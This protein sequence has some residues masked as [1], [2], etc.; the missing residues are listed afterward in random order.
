MCCSGVNIHFFHL[1]FLLFAV[2][3]PTVNL[4]NK[5]EMN[6]LASMEFNVDIANGRNDQANP[7]H[8]ALDIYER[9]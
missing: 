2:G 9:I 1:S 3:N 6:K 7:M 8:E 4:S 5:F